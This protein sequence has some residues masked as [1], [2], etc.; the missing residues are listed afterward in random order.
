MSPLAIDGEEQ[1]RAE[2]AHGQRED[3]TG[4]EQGGLVEGRHP[5]AA[6]EDDTD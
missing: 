2:Q 3:G 6:Q 5:E 4:P 1:G